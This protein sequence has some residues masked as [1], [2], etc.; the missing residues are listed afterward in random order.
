MVVSTVTYFDIK[1]LEGML[2]I[3]RL[4]GAGVLV[5]SYK[6]YPSRKSWSVWV[7]IIFGLH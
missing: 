1:C 5:A 3:G 2:R 7:D 6:V 4:V